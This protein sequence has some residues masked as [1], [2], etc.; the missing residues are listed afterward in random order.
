[1]RLRWSPWSVSAGLVAYGAALAVCAGCARKT[2]ET[3]PARSFVPAAKLE[4]V[5]SAHILA[6]EAR[7]LKQGRFSGGVAAVNVPRP[8]SPA[9]IES[10]G[11]LEPPDIA[12]IRDGLS[13]RISAGLKQYAAG[14]KQR[15]LRSAEIAI[16]Q[17]RD[18]RSGELEARLAELNE[19]LAAETM[20]ARRKG[21]AE[22]AGL[23]FDIAV[24]KVQSG[25]APGSTDE[26][27]RQI[28]G[29]ESRLAEI[30]K[31]VEAEIGQIEARRR[32]SERAARAAWDSEMDDFAARHRAR[33][34]VL[35]EQQERAR[36]ALLGETVESFVADLSVD[37][38]RMPSAARSPGPPPTS[39]AAREEAVKRQ[40]AR[41]G[42]RMEARIRQDAVTASSLARASQPRK[43]ARDAGGAVTARA[44]SYVGGG[45]H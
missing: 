38:I 42:D 15:E 28:A 9:E 4:P 10:P 39:A 32:E 45:E 1:M 31:R 11:L 5:R 35:A 30:D 44:A 41:A 25:A 37:G 22:R 43:G 26:V 24:L 21:A 20:D 2:P 23:Q 14:V 13:G 16:R 33:A 17:E 7:A 29:K 18:R 8:L 6:G 12:H 34:L 19:R 3:S 27:V 36:A 40:L